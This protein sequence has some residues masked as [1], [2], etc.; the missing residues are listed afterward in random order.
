M[1]KI[2]MKVF[3]I[4]D[5]SNAR[6]YWSEIS[7]PNIDL[8]RSN[9]ADIYINQPNMKV[10]PEINKNAFPDGLRHTITINPK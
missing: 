4:I 3:Y 8:A 9:A 1:E 5:E 10:V 6:K 7:A 2:E